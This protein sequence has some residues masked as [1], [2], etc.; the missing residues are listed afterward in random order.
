MDTKLSAPWYIYANKLRALFRGDDDISV[1]DIYEGN[2]NKYHLA[3]EIYNHDKFVALDYL[4]NKKIDFGN[5]KLS[6]DLYDLDTST[7][8]DETHLLETLF[9]DNPVYCGLENV[10]DDAGYLHWY[11]IMDN[12]GLG[13]DADN[14]ADYHGK[15][16]QLPADIAK[17]VF[18]SQVQFCTIDE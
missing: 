18:N 5:V 8:F 12:K 2:D 9:N 1:T 17:E 10:T 6:I 14:T 16:H 7:N 3:I 11:A 4:L 15:I 13:Y